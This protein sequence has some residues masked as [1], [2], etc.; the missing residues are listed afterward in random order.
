MDK[1]RDVPMDW[2]DALLVVSAEETGVA[3]VLTL[4]Q[5]GFLSYRMHGR[6]P[7]QLFPRVR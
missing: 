7:F 2:V 5:R 6:K 3:R 1:Y 4:D